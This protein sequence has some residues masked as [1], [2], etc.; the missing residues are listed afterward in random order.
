M[1]ANNVY[2]QAPGDESMVIEGVEYR[3]GDKVKLVLNK[4]RSDASDMLLAGK[5]AT[6]EMIYTDYEDKVYLA[7][8][9]D[10]DPAQQMHRELNIYRYFLP[11]EV[12][13]I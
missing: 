13:I 11:D 2:N 5:V 6:I 1:R 8:T 4:R 3:K 7:V 10:E 12:E 9:V